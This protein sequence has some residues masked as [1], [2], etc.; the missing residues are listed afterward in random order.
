MVAVLD[1]YEIEYKESYT[2][3]TYDQVVMGKMF[4]QISEGG[5][6]NYVY[7]NRG[8]VH[9]NIN[10]TY[11]SIP[12][13]GIFDKSTSRSYRSQPYREKSGNVR[14]A[15]H[16]CYQERIYDTLTPEAISCFRKNGADIFCFVKDGDETPGGSI[17]LSGV[18]AWDNGFIIFDSYIPESG[19]NFNA[20]VDRHWTRSFPFEPRYA[21]VSR[22]KQ[23]KFRNGL[24][25]AKYKASF[26]S[27]SFLSAANSYNLSTLSKRNKLRGLIVGTVGP[28]RG[29]FKN[30]TNN[31]YLLP[32]GQNW[33]HRWAVDMDSEKRL[34][35][36]PTVGGNLTGSVTDNDML[37]I[38][39]G[40]GDINTVFYSSSY[41]DSNNPT[42]Y[43]ML[44]T[45][46]WP[47]FRINNV[48]NINPMLMGDYES[49]TGSVWCTSPI[50][51]GW[52]YG[53]H[54]ALEDY[55][56]AYYRQGKYGQFR[57]MLEQ[58]Q[59]TKFSQEAV[60]DSSLRAGIS[61]SP[62]TIKFVDADGNIT[63]PDRTQSQNLSYEATSSLPYFDLTQ[64]ARPANIRG[65]TNLSI[66]NFSVDQFGNVA[67]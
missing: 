60:K 13:S 21:N 40:Y 10:N 61:S 48:T 14:A 26:Y 66:V 47:D 16:F 5:I 38:L 59:F 9:G 62:V 50:I 25:E 12:G 23:Q 35:I 11:N 27:T 37:K 51:R 36:P 42:G 58:R 64:R 53:L 63:E 6:K 15:K 41:T 34:I 31:K 54:N 24:I 39:F 3:G 49:V 19:S 45:N 32:N 52:K 57:D 20:G 17:P 18:D 43:A 29:V 67:L 65:L 44:G 28:A 46:N 8:I 22:Q 4:Y 2:S 56:S 33:K 7:G 30:N 1:Q 55:S